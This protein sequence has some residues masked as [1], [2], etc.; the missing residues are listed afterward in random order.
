MNFYLNKMKYTATKMNEYSATINK[1]SATTSQF[2]G[3]LTQAYLD[4]AEGTDTLLKAY[5]ELKQAVLD[6]VDAYQKQQEA[7]QSNIDFAN[8]ICQCFKKRRI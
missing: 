6:N 3:E 1:D 7:I 2:I 8:Y 5:P 4:D